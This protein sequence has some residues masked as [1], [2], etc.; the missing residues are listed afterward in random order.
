MGVVVQFTSLDGQDDEVAQLK[1]LYDELSELVGASR[2][3]RLWIDAY[4]IHQSTQPVEA[5]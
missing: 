1:A 5:A 3:V 2:A 4:D